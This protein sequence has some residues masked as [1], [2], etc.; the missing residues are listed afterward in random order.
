MADDI[1]DVRAELRALKEQ[2]R[3]LMTANPLESS[4]INKGR[5]R[6]I[7]GLLRI[8][9]GG[10]FEL[11]GTMEGSGAIIWEGTIDQ[12][13]STFLRGPVAITGEDGT[14]TVDAETLLRGLTRILAD[15]QVEAGGKIVTGNVR[16]ED[17]K[18]YVGAGDEIVIDGATSEI[19]VGGLTIDPADHDGM[20]TFP[21][22]GQLLAFEGNIEL[23]SA[24]VGG[25]SSVRVSPDG[26]G[27]TLPTADNLTGLQWVGYQGGRLV[28]VPQNVGG[29][30]GGPLAWPFP[31][32]T[33]SSEFGPR[34]APGQGGST[35]HQ[36]IDLAPGAG[37]PIPAAGS[38]VV[39]LAGVNG[40][41][42]N[43]VIIDHGNGLRTLYGHMQ[44]TPSVSVGQTVAAGQIIGLVGNTGVS[45]GAHLHLEVHVNGVP[46][47]PRSKLP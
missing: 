10:R 12:T 3:I 16:I 2:V 28:R 31:P 8:D 25:R 44:D 38:G 15:L 27:V 32:S 17:G 35:D 34:D 37:L 20:I 42:G 1:S 9:S 22:G 30:M 41:F 5:V 47:N 13:G 40:G 7:G 14:L 29:P 46:V 36:G 33:V 23:Y 4:S 21:N 18:I 43:C 39:A 19:R 26:V 24:D 11:E 6:F 45:F